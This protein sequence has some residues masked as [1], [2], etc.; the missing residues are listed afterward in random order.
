MVMAN[1]SSKLSLRN[2]VNS[3]WLIQYKFSKLGYIKHYGQSIR[4]QPFHNTK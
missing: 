2:I 4:Q 1:L 3:T